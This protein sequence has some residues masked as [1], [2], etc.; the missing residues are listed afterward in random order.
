MQIYFNSRVSSGVQDLPGNNIHYGHPVE[1]KNKNQPDFYCLQQ[2][3]V[4]YKN[5]KSFRPTS[6][7]KTNGHENERCNIILKY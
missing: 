1:K 7:V 4:P 3:M 6:A 2:R 5:R